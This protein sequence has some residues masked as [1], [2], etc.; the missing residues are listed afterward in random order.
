MMSYLDAYI[1]PRHQLFQAA[2][3]MRCRTPAL[4]GASIPAV[5]TL[6]AFSRLSSRVR[7]GKMTRARE[8]RERKENKEGQY[9]PPNDGSIP[10]GHKTDF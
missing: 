10:I 6:S 4:F 5:W 3:R 2:S 9:E 7:I 1:F 8:G